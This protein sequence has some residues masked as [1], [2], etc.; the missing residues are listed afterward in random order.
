MIAEETPYEGVW[1][2]FDSDPKCE[3]CDRSLI[4]RFGGQPSSE[5]DSCRDDFNR[6]NAA[7]KL[8]LVDEGT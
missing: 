7:G 4:G 3:W 8:E 6:L 5:C 2:P 1:G